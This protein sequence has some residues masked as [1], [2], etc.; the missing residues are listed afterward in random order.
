VWTLQAEYYFAQ[1]QYDL[2]ALHY[3]KTS[4]SFEEITLRFIHIGEADALRAFLK[5]KLRHMNTNR[6]LMHI[7]I[8]CTWLTELYLNKLNQLE[9]E[10]QS[11]TNATVGQLPTGPST[12]APNAS[13]A[14]LQAFNASRAAS[15]FDAVLDEF[16][17]FLEEYSK[18]KVLDPATTFNL[19]SS[20]GRTKV[21]PPP[22]LSYFFCPLPFIY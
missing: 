10:A 2:A 14:S 15:A 3:G 19:I 21:R 20:H 16:R 12:A 6:D 18:L 7:T 17:S 13:A 11:A 4:K 22:T 1:K 8:L 5:E 9:A